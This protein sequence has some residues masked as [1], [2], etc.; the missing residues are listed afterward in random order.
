MSTFQPSGHQPV[1]VLDPSSAG[2]D[3]ELRK[4]ALAQIERKRRF[5]S[6]AVAYAAI[7]I[8]V[9][10][11][12]AVSEYHNAGGWP[13]DGFSQSSG[14]PH[15][16]NIWVIYPLIVLGVLLGVDAWNTYR[17]RPVLESDVRREMDRLK[18]GRD[19]G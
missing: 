5:E 17:R 1:D 15:V 4:A 13:S 11:G 18:R 3:H 12:W 9:V 10:I 7:S 16:W 14:T 19:G 8:V 2:G 6:H